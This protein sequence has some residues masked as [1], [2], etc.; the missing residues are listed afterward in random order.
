MPY[1]VAIVLAALLICGAG[2]FAIRWQVVVNNNIVYRLDR[3]TGEIRSC[4]L[5]TTDRNLFSCGKP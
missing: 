5:T 4:A 2:L 1:P 3:W